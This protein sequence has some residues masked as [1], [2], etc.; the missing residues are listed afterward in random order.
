MLWQ[1]GSQSINIGKASN[2]YVGVCDGQKLTL[3]INGVREHSV[4]DPVLRD[5]YVGVSV[6]SFEIV[7]VLVEV[8][9]LDI[10]LP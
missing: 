7:P 4:T 1:G 6:S 8:E 2:D 5:G 10:S 9:W 3:Y